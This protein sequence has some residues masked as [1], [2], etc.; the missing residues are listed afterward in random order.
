M[1][2]PSLMKPRSI[3]QNPKRVPRLLKKIGISRILGPRSEAKLRSHSNRMLSSSPNRHRIV[4][5]TSTI[6]KLMVTILTSEAPCQRNILRHA[7][8][9]VIKR[10]L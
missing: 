2:N 1:A 9:Q 10:R 4:L 8:N 3:R 5:S 6:V 7:F